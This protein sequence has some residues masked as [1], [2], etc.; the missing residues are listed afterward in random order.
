ML[1]VDGKMCWVQE[2]KVVGFHNARPNPMRIEN[3]WTSED[4]ELGVLYHFG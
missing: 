3:S 4:G 1:V 2:V